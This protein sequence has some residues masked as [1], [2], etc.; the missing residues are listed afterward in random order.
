MAKRQGAS[1][2]HHD[3]GHHDLGPATG[4]GLSFTCLACCALDLHPSIHQGEALYAMELSLSLEK[5][6]F[7]KLRQLQ[8]GLCALFVREAPVLPLA[9]V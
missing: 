6:N 5:L 4:A 3:L 2:G 8:V 7:Q 1:L 9:R